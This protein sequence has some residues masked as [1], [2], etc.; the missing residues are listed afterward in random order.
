MRAQILAA[1]PYPLQVVIGFIAYRKVSGSLY[2]QGT[3]RFAPDELSAFKR[4]GWQ[5]VNAL[6]VEA[7][8]SSRRANEDRDAVFWVWGRDEPSEADATLF[9][10]I[11]SVLVST[12]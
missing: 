3:G 8:R 12:A 7:K 5:S 11:A 9:G 10:F 1:L 2:G 4:E 6:L